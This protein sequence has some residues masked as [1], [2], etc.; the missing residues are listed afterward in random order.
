MRRRPTCIRLRR[1]ARIVRQYWRDILAQAFDSTLELGGDTRKTLLASL[2]TWGVQALRE[3]WRSSEVDAGMKVLHAAIDGLIPVVTVLGVVFAYH[4]IA[5]P[6]KV[7]RIQVLDLRRERRRLRVAEHGARERIDERAIAVMLPKLIF[8]GQE[9]IKALCVDSDVTSDADLRAH[10]DAYEAWEERVCHLY[11]DH[12]AGYRVFAIFAPTAVKRDPVQMERGRRL[13]EAKA[14]LY[15]EIADG[16]A[17]LR[18]EIQRLNVV[19][20]YREPNSKRDA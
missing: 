13:T 11:R 9:L 1:W 18:T 2:A 5:T 10:E 14:S 12:G 15:H 6:A 8:Q 20:P 17:A 19:V 16:I 3:F 7:H 4:L